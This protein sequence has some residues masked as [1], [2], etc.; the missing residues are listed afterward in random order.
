MRERNTRSTSNPTANKILPVHGFVTATA[1][2]SKIAVEVI[3][4]YQNC[5]AQASHS[6]FTKKAFV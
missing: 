6:F 3:K 1:A 5:E 4:L 2:F